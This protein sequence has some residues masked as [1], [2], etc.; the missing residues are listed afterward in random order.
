DSG[1]ERF[2]FTRVFSLQGKLALSKISDTDG[3][4]IHLAYDI[5]SRITSVTDSSGRII[6]FTY[7]GAN[8]ILSVDV[9]HPGLNQ[10]PF[11]LAFFEYSASGE[12]AAAYDPAGRVTRYEYDSHFLVA[13]TNVWGGTQYF[14]YDDNGWAVAT[15]RSDAT[16][17]RL[18]R[19]TRDTTA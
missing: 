14:A 7:D 6:R 9:S 3:N 1:G 15:W 8:H 19:R 18:I 16:E 10:P 2:I 17:V 5:A 4:T 11:T 12:L 13:L